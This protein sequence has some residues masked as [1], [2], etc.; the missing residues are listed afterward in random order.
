[1]KDL[2]GFTN[3]G[4]LQAGGNLSL[5]TNGTLNNA[6]GTLSSG[7]MMTL[8]A[9]KDIDL[10]SSSVRASALSLNAGQDII[11]AT[12]TQTTQGNR[13][14][15]TQ[16]G[17]TASIAV[18]GDTSITTGRN[19]N[20]A[21]AT[22]ATGGNLN[23]TTGGN[24]SIGTVT[25]NEA[26]TTQ[27]A[28]GAAASNFT[29]NLGSTITVGGNTNA[30]VG[31]DLNISGSTLT[32]GTSARNTASIVAGGSI[33][34]TA[35][36][37]STNVNSSYA[38]GTYRTTS[39]TVKSASLT[40]AGGLTLFAGKDLSIIGSNVGS[41]GNT[42]IGASGNVTIAAQRSTST[43][44]A[45]DSGSKGGLGGK[46]ETKTTGFNREITGSSITGNNIAIVSKNANVIL[47][48]A[49]VDATN[50]LNI[51]AVNGVVALLSASS[52]SYFQTD[53]KESNVA[54]QRMSGSGTYDKN[55]V[56]TKLNFGA[57]GLS[58]EANKIIADLPASKGVEEL[59][60]QPGMGWITQLQ[61][62]PSRKSRLEED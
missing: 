56:L 37:D 12:A 41:A 22:L 2:K 36:L 31:G 30:N 52:E 23:V 51:S 7:R 15:K 48:A 34:I 49:N 55:A 61:N 29:T 44:D 32:L 33:S 24:W 59:A 58:I 57:G 50:S 39:E 16:I 60:K 43:L 45:Q 4:T 20:M 35:A 38:G 54:I 40:S 26:K 19:F 6:F 25:A 42:L 3:A 14:S 47:E 8:A 28:G 10:T 21:G 1:L 13:F 62:D 53:K 46:E 9:D 18:T 17:Q 27:T 11:L 5:Q